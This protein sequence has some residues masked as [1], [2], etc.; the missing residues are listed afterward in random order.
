MR[1]VSR[2]LVWHSGIFLLVLGLVLVPLFFLIL[3][4]FSTAR[5]PGDFSLDAMSWVNYVK[6]Y[7]DQI[8]RAHV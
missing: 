6:V 8:G 2:P 3:G 4:S 1:V 7:S 5:L